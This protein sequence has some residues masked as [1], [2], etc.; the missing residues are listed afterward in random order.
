MP[1][2]ENVVDA[3]AGLAIVC[4]V[5][6]VRYSEE[7]MTRHRYNVYYSGDVQGVG[8]RYTACRLAQMV[9]IT[10]FVR[11]L[12]DGRVQLV[13]EGPVDQL[14]RFLSDLASEMGGY[15]HSRQLDKQEPTREFSSFS[16]RR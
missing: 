5:A 3:S 6:A 2:R 14:D 10:G 16:L 8:F 11:N 1:C 9:D 13:A 4:S 15:I 12:P 7:L